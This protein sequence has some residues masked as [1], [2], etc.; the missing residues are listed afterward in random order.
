MN[1][2]LTIEQ[3]ELQN[4]MKIVADENIRPVTDI[5][6]AGTVKQASVQLKKN[7]KKLA[8]EGFLQTFL[9]D[10]LEGYCVMGEE[11]AKA[12]PATFFSAAS[13]AAFF[14]LA[15]KIFGTPSQKDY[16]IPGLLNDGLIGSLAVTEADA[17]SDLAGL[18]TVAE[19]RGN[20]WVLNGTKNFVTNAPIA[21]AFLVMAW[22]GKGAG[23]SNGMTLFV[24]N[25]KTKGLTVSKPIE[26]LGLRGALIAGVELCNCEVGEEA[27]VGS[28]TG[29]G[30]EQYTRIMPFIHLTLSLYSLGVGVTC[31]EESTTYSKQRTAFG[32]PIG[33]FE[34]VGAKLAVMFTLLDLGRMMTFKAAWAMKQ[35]DS[36]ATILASCAKLFTSESVNK[37]SDMA[38]QIHAG[39]GYIKGSRV[40]KL[41]RDARFAEIAYDTSERLRAYIAKN[42]LDK[43]SKAAS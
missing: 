37:I 10:D 35:N 42:S 7:L 23:I 29:K 34:N 32:K 16:Y 8:T 21:D 12:C 26:T 38:M 40:E 14:G 36:E 22:T 4:K 25:R 5:L 28:E 3:K 1:Y 20:K 11:L 17:A 41:Y 2:E 9:G 27:I 31:M 6:D 30:Y 33:Y 19:K 39:H 24:V 18:K 43:Y 13:S 15:L